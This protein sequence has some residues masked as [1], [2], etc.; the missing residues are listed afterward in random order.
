[1]HIRARPGT[2]AQSHMDSIRITIRPGGLTHECERGALLAD[3]LMDMGIMVRTPCGGKGICGKCAIHADGGLDGGE[4]R[5]EKGPHNGRPYL[6]CRAKTVGDVTVY[7]PET[8]PLPSKKKLSLPPEARLGVAVD[9]GTTTIQISLVPEGGAP[10]FVDSLMNPQRRFGHDIISRIAASR[11]RNIRS[12]ITAAARNAIASSLESVFSSSDI[13]ASRIDTIAVSGNTAMMYFLF[14]MDALPLGEYPYTARRLD[15]DNCTPG[16]IGLHGMP[17]ARLYAL[18]AAS[19]FLGGDSIGGLALAEASGYGTSLFFIDLGTN[20]EIF[21]RDG[22]GAALGTS[23]AMGPALEGMNIAYGMTAGDGAISHVRRTNATWLPTVIGGGAPLGI[24]GT[25]IID[26]LAILLRDGIVGTDG[27]I[28]PADP[29]SSV[30]RTET[31]NGVRAVPIHGEIALTQKDIRAIQ[32]AKGASR[33]ASHILLDEAGITPGGISDVLLAGAFG[34]NLDIDNFR[35][36]GFIPDFPNAR[37]HFLGNSS[38][39]AAERACF[40]TSFISRA[41]SLRDG[42][43]IIDLATHRRF[44]DEFVQSI[45]FL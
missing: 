4:M 17:N 10:L 22:Q 42:I 26:M 45:S 28:R 21:V 19:A 5:D 36:L 25:G 31:R 43:R 14:G 39:A 34:E 41:K 6:A 44:N 13:A 3:A 30:A 20:G 1:M 23:C 29:E 37:Y 12:R 2:L 18:P 16:D 11:D 35:A 40:D 8:A 27:A 32:L 24:C 9:V 7:M 15:F 38:L 33:A